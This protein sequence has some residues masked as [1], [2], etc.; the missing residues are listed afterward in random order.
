[1][2][3]DLCPIEETTYT[4]KSGLFSHLCTSTF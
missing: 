1:L 4:E 2:V 3:F